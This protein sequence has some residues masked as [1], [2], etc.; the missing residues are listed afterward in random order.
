MKNT[1]SVFPDIELSRINRIN[2]HRSSPGQRGPGQL[3]HSSIE[4]Y[5]EADELAGLCE[6]VGPGRYRAIALDDKGKPLGK[7]WTC[8]VIAQEP[9]PKPSTIADDEALRALRAAHQEELT[10]LRDTLRE[11]AREEL[12]TAAEAAERRALLERE[13]AELDAARRIDSAERAAQAAVDALDA[14]NARK[15]HEFARLQRQIETLTDERADFERRNAMA[16]ERIADLE[17][18][19][20]EDRLRLMEQ[21]QRLEGDLSVARRTHEAELRE[22]R[23]G[24]PEIRSLAAKWEIEKSKT[25]LEHELMERESA[26]SLMT[27]LMG[28]IQRPEV[29]EMLFPVLN[30]IAEAIFAP[31]QAVKNS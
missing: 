15:E 21:I 11:R 1:S 28:A 12:T 23:Q 9:T 6:Q 22:L 20:G 26:N 27:K 14:A 24:P 4:S 3:V 7:A 16:R 30:S 19:A 2:L 25:L 5:V 8:E 18:A 13:M 17:R 29:Q 31:K 10:A